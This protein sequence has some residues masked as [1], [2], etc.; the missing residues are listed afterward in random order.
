MSRISSVVN[1]LRNGLGA[2]RL[3]PDVKKVTLTFSGKSDNAGPRYFIR[4]NMPRIQYN[5]PTIQF[6]VKKVK[7]AN[8]NPELTVDQQRD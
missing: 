3:R 8:V 1:D 4:E 7:E 5:N 6:E 2:I